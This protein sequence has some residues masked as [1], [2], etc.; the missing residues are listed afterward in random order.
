MWAACTTHDGH[1]AGHQRRAR[2]RCQH[3]DGERRRARRAGRAQDHDRVL[4]G[5]LLQIGRRQGWAKRGGAGGRVSLSGRRCHTP[6]ARAPLGSLGGEAAAQAAPRGRVPP[7]T[8]VLLRGCLRLVQPRPRDVGVVGVA[9]AARGT[10]LGRRQAAAA[11]EEGGRPARRRKFDRQARVAVKRGRRGVSNL[12]PCCTGRVPAPRRCP[13]PH[14]AATPSMVR[15]W[16][17][18]SN[19]VAAV[20]VAFR[21]GTVNGTLMLC[22]GAGWFM[23]RGGGWA[24]GER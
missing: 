7:L 1:L 16:I 17:I 9:A 24:A 6:E 19:S 11:G 21:L 10:A 14:S 22:T 13:R 23:G 8:D 12:L 5:E 3:S 15:S 4:A 18:R 20:A 2:Q